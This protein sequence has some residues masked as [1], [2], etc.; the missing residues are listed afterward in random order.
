[1]PL[2]AL[3]CG[4]VLQLREN[5]ADEREDHQLRVYQRALRVRRTALRALTQAN[6][7]GLGLAPAACL[8]Y[9]NDWSSKVFGR[10]HLLVQDSHY[11]NP[12]GL[13]EIEH[14]VAPYLKSPQS[15]SDSIAVPADG[16]VVS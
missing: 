7:T 15:G 5:F 3:K 14:N 13:D 1:V 9:K 6:K 4:G 10:Q 2:Y 11:K 8:I 12:A 16:G